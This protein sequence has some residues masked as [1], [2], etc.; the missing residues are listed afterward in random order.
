MTY[1]LAKHADG[2][3]ILP[4]TVQRPLLVYIVCGV[5]HLASGMWFVPLAVPL[6]TADTAVDVDACDAHCRS[7]ADALG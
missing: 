7:F 4:D 6:H 5:R 3:V 2:I 1:A